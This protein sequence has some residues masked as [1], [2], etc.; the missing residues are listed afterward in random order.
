M[1]STFRDGTKTV[2]QSKFQN[3]DNDYSGLN[4]FAPGLEINPA[5]G[6]HLIIT[7]LNDSSSFI[8][9]IGG[10]NQNITPVCGRGERK[11]YSVSSDGS[12][13][14]A[15][16]KLSNAGKIQIKNEL[17]SFLTI[18]DNF[19]NVFINSTEFTFGSP[20]VHGLLPDIKTQI[21]QVKTQIDA[22][23]EA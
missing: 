17:Y 19:L 8:V 5:D 1:Q 6:E 11:L 23:M 14:K 16:I 4:C 9:T 21:Q 13:E 15:S 10:V 12:T 3:N 18:L 2:L 20:S 7:K 22:L